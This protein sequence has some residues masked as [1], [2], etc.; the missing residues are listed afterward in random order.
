[1]APYPPELV[2]QGVEGTVILDLVV[3]DSGRVDSA[4]VVKGVHPA[5]DSAALHA[6]RAFI[7]TP[8]LAAGKPV[9][10]LMQY[11]YHFTIGE[12]VKA[13]AEYINFKGRI[14]ERGAVRPLSMLR[15]L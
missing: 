1:M 9:P 4:A 6:S 10:V 3:S 11:A 2:K 8:A 5:L 15:S 13:I 7:F 12:V 14:V